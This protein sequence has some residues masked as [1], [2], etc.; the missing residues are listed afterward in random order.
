MLKKY[1]RS[2]LIEIVNIMIVAFIVVVDNLYLE[3]V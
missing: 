3:R 1:E 2:V